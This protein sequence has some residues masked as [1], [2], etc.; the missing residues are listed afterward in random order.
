M[1]GLG[2][3]LLIEC[4]PSIGKSLSSIISTMK[5]ECWCVLQA[6]EAFRVILDYITVH[7]KSG[8]HVTL[9][10][11]EMRRGREGG[12]GTEGGERE[13]GE[14]GGGGGGGER[15]RGGG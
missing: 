5:P 12:R 1:L 8:F 9:P 11:R 15:R 10:D 6:D 7:S 14:G 2:T 4:L 13:E 3:G